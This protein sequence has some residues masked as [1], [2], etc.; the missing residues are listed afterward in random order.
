MSQPNT[1]SQPLKLKQK[2]I[3]IGM[4]P[5]AA[6]LIV[7]SLV[8]PAS[9][10]RR[11]CDFGIG[12]VGINCRDEFDPPDESYPSDDYRDYNRSDD[13]RSYDRRLDNDRA[14]RVINDYYRQYL[15]RDADPEG[16]EDWLNAYQDGQ[17]LEQIR[18][19]IANSEEAR[20]YERSTGYN[21]RY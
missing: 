8:T 21:Y 1:F 18:R 15:G 12:G 16:L 9:A 2:R 4:I 6:A 19:N 3:A 7:G 14:G 10:Q 20:N 17:S 13:Y 11:V 5:L